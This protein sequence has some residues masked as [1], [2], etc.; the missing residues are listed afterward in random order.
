MT[1]RVCGGQ[2]RGQV[3]DSTR[4]E[5]SGRGVGGPPAPGLSDSKCVGREAGL[6]DSTVLGKTV[7]SRK[8]YSPVW[9]G[10]EAG[11]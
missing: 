5:R 3:N 6:S 10:R 9:V 1:A 11:P 4:A 7:R 2:G 8:S